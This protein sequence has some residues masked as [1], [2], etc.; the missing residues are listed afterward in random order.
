MKIVLRLIVLTLLVVQASVTE[1][2][3]GTWWSIETH[4]VLDRS[5]EKESMVRIGV[6]HTIQPVACNEPTF[7][8]GVQY[9]VTPTYP[10]RFNASLESLQLR[11]DR[12][13]VRKL[14][15]EVGRKDGVIHLFAPGGF[16][17]SL[18]TPRNATWGMAR[19][20]VFYRGRST[21]TNIDIVFCVSRP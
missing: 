6:T 12:E 5:R 19:F 13:D 17:L 21:G 2:Q 14:F 18:P 9:G 15:D 20:T 8:I 16:T 4:A 7:V 11:P 3:L 10:D 1:A